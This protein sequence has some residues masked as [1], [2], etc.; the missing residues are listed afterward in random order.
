[1]HFLALT[2]LGVCGVHGVAPG[3]YQTMSSLY[4]LC[5]LPIALE[6]VSEARFKLALPLVA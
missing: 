6:T 3:S 5:C 1:M 2:A 4:S